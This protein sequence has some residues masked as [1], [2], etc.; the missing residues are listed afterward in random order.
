MNLNDEQRSRKER[1]SRKGG[2]KKKKKKKAYVGPESNPRFSG[3][4]GF[5]AF[6]R[7]KLLFFGDAANGCS[8]CHQ[9]LAELQ[10][11][12]GC[13]YFADHFTLSC[14]FCFKK[15]KQ[16][17]KGDP[18]AALAEVQVVVAEL[19]TVTLDEQF[20]LFFYQLFFFNKR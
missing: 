13:S 9:T 4:L 5:G 16:T 19:D 7:L 6:W 3:Y 17:L 10:V 11:F 8:E 1:K 2:T 15:P 14:L 18:V 20:A 12:W